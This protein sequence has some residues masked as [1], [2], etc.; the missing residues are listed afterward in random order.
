MNSP[1]WIFFRRS[2]GPAP[3]QRSGDR[4][5]L[6]SACWRWCP[7]TRDLGAF[8]RLLVI[9]CLLPVCSAWAG[10]PQP[11]DYPESLRRE[12]ASLLEARAQGSTN[13]DPLTRL[14]ALYLD[15]GD[16]LFNDTAS[17]IAAY[18]EGARLAQRAL[19]LDD[20]EANAHFLYAANLGNAMYLKGIVASAMGVM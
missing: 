6:S 9:A 20:T 2:S 3:S 16:N 15:M 11:P 18:E 5:T 1:A 7:S 19:D 12:L 17:R 13:P 10:P 4:C 8:R 14:A